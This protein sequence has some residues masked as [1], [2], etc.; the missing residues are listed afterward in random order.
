MQAA[1]CH[2]ATLAHA[3]KLKLNMH[4]HLLDHAQLFRNIIKFE[5]PLKLN[6]VLAYFTVFG[7][8]G[9]SWMHLKFRGMYSIFQW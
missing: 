8:T 9:I 3:R 1:R 2:N 4:V 6:V 7:K 5:C